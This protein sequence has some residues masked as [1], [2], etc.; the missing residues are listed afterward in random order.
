MI[1]RSIALAGYAIGFMKLFRRA[2]PDIPSA[3]D[4]TPGFFAALA[5]IAPLAGSQTYRFTTPDGE[6]RGVVQFC[7]CPAGMVTIHRLWTP[8]PGQGHG[9]TMLIQLCNLADRH[10]VPILL[11]A[12]PFGKKPYPMS[13]EQLADWYRRHGFDGTHKRLLRT[14][15]RLI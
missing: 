4:G 7:H 10:G 13:R 6:C 15:R 5:I 3:P 12:L 8:S 9:S 11:K 2:Q 1:W 14:P